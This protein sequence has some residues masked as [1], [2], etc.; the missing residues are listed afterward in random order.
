M[1]LVGPSIGGMAGGRAAVAPLS[2]LLLLAACQPD[3]EPPVQT[4]AGVD[5]RALIAVTGD[6]RLYLVVFR[7]ELAD[8]ARLAEMPARLCA[9]AGEKLARARTRAPYEPD[10]YPVGTRLMFVECARAQVAAGAMRRHR[11]AA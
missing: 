5:R 4:I 1:K 6:P 7:P 3:A 11:G 2:A 8:P 9:E 10:A